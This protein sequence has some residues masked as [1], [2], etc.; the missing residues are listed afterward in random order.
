LRG[1]TV[2]LEDTAA[3]T[4]TD[5][6]GLAVQLFNG[7]WELL[8]KENRT[9]AEDDRMMH[10]AHASRFHWDNVGDDHHRAIGEWQV[11]RVYTVLGRG[12]A[13]LFHARRSLDYASR[14][15]I[16]DWLLASA[17]EGLARAQAVAGEVEAARDSRET[18]LGL[19]GKVAD[20]EDRK[21]VA[22]DIDTLPIPEA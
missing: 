8:E 10:M 11:S 4:V 19:L 7:T 16:D 9:P 21:V 2:T 13:A 22:A 17:Y 18:A 20:P 5:E 14:P 15:G 3:Q 1:V 6:R 12:E